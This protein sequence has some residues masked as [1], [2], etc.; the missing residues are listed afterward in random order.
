MGIDIA[1]GMVYLHSADPPIVHRD[2]KSP[3]LL[4]DETFTVKLTYCCFPTAACLLLSWL[5]GQRE[6]QATQSAALCWI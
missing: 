5:S 2:L 6:S 4:V 1:K 3:N